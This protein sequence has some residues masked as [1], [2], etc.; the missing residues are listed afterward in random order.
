MFSLSDADLSGRILGAGDG[1]ASFNAEAHR[2]GARVISCDPLY[3]CSTTVLRRRFDQTSAAVLA[4]TERNRQEFVWSYFRDIDALART[5]HEAFERFV[6]DF[7]DGCR[8]GRYVCAGLPDLPFRDRSFDLAL[9]SHFLFLY[10]EQLDFSFH[11][12]S[13]LELCRV[14]DEVRVFP[15][16]ALGSVPSPH[17]EPLIEELQRRKIE[18]EIEPVDYEFQ[19]GGCQQ[20]RIRVR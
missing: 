16:L 13:L 14:A 17:V 10:S 9:C 1:P 7:V 8:A 2:L 6:T 18:F 20:L 3:R 15:L 11:S 4:E 19:R 5:R 12:R